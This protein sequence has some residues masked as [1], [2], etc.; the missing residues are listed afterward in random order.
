M[1]GSRKKEYLVYDVLRQSAIECLME[2]KNYTDKLILITMRNNKENLDW[3]LDKLKIKRLFDE[4]IICKCKENTNKYD[5]VENFKVNRGIV[6]GD[7][8]HDIELSI[9]CQLKCIAITS[10]LREKK[11]LDSDFYAEEIKDINMANLI[12]KIYG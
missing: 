1:K 9:A 11:Y 7:T 4:I 8:E 6:I 12:K 2:W 5:F 3:Q 10:G